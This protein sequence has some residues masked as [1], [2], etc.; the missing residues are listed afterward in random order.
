[1]VLEPSPPHP[2]RVTTTT[3]SLPSSLKKPVASTVQDNNEVP[4]KRKLACQN[5]RRRRR[6]CNMEEPCSNCIKFSTDCVFT[7]L[8]LRNK[9]YSTT[10]VEALQNQIRTLKEQLQILKSSSST[11]AS[12]SLSSLNDDDE[13]AVISNGKDLK[14]GESPSSALP[15]SES[16]DENESDTFTKKLPSESPPPVGTNSIY[17]SNSLSIIKKKN[18]RQHKIPATGQFEEFIEKSSHL[19]VI[20]ALL[21]MVVP[22]SLSFHT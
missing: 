15:S 3:P 7:Q 14:Y 17:P 20:I 11:I 9:R 8:D 5:C 4:R 1:M 13:R 18:G 16:N 6:K 10:Y 19:K 22:R 2:P 21:Q 12:G